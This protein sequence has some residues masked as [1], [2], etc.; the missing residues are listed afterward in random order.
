MLNNN[1]LNIESIQFKI[2]NNII[3]Y[4]DINMI[5]FTFISYFIKQ[6]L[7][8]LFNIMYSSIIMFLIWKSYKINAQQIPAPPYLPQ[9]SLTVDSPY[10]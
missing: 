7:I 8:T 5:Y 2:H 9:L 3:Q 10:L 4:L 1:I 6:C